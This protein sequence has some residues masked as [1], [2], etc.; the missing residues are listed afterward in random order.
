MKLLLSFTTFILLSCSVKNS[1]RD[2][3][4]PFSPPINTSAKFLI[5]SGYEPLRENIDV[6]VLHKRISDSTSYYFQFG[7]DASMPPEF[8]ISEIILPQDSSAFIRLL[9]RYNSQIISDITMINSETELFYIRNNL[10]HMFFKSTLTK[11]DSSFILQ[12]NFSMPYLSELRN[13]ENLDRK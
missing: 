6:I 8:F 10:N 9:G 13:K 4:D 7:E 1:F 3:I 12:N 5:E 2:A 11:T